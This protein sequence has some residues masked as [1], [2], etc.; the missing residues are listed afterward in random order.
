M[1]NNKNTMNSSTKTNNFDTN[2]SCS[3]IY[4]Y[5]CGYAIV[6]IASTTA[7]P[8]KYYLPRVYRI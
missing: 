2:G 6:Y 4:T 8:S 3:Y 1:L 7:L 5:T